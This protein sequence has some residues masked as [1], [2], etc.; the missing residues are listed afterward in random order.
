[1]AQQGEDA[2]LVFRFGVGAASLGWERLGEAL[3]TQA[4]L[5]RGDGADELQPPSP[6]HLVVAALLHAPELLAQVANAPRLLSRTWPGRLGGIVR[7]VLARTPPAREAAR[8]SCALAATLGKRASELVEEG[9]HEEAV[10]RELARR[11][12][13]AAV[14]RVLERIASSAELQTLI[15]EQSFGLTRDALER[16]RNASVRADDLFESLARRVT[17]PRGD[18]TGH[19]DGAG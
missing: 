1:V 17:R 2:R 16:L 15:K 19:K 3:R 8:W 14:E 13:G 9:R 11:T 4:A 18:G 12:I 5:G 7:D 10:G 6:L